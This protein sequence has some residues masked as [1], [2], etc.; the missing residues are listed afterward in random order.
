MLV[1]LCTVAKCIVFKNIV[2]SR[3][4]ARSN[5]PLRRKLA[6]QRR[7]YTTQRF[8]ENRPG[9]RRAK[10]PEPERTE[11]REDYEIVTATP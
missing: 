10:Y 3:K 2:V 5:V 1:P 8:D 6:I 11:V 4:R 9:T 7:L